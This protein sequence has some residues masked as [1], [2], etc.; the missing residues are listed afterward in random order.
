MRR[1]AVVGA[2][3]FVGSALVERL[4][5][6]GADEVVPFIHSSGN[7][8]RLARRGI[9]LRMLDLLDSTQV[10]AA[11]SGITHVVN[12]SRGDEDVMLTGLRNLLAASRKRGSSG[13][14]I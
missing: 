8:M 10:E 3:G 4:L 6:Q 5:V 12:C 7:A 2:S 9:E 13:S 14:F 11:L 1:I